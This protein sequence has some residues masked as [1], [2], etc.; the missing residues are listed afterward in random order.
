M[1]FNIFLNKKNIRNYIFIYRFVS[2]VILYLL[3]LDEKIRTTISYTNAMNVVK[4]K[5]I[6]LK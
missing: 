6:L 5:L 4:L 1:N 2:I 3:S